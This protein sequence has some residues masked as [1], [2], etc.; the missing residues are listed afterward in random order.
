MVKLVLLFKKPDDE[1]A[2]EARYNKNL[3]LLEK[4]PGITRRQANVVL[5]SPAGTSPYYRILEFYFDDFYTLDAAITSEAGRAAGG[6]LMQ[7]A[8]KLVELIFVD[9]FEDNTPAS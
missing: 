3:A 4:M 2:F 8:G 1:D 9:V 6:D 5:G 7:Y